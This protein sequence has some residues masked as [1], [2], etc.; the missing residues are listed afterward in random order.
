MLTLFTGL[1]KKTAVLGQI[2]L[3]C[4]HV[5]LAIH[6]HSHIIHNKVICYTLLRGAVIAKHGFIIHDSH[7]DFAINFS[8]V[9]SKEHALFFVQTVLT[10][11]DQCVKFSGLEQ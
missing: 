2:T 3:N 1:K 11:K 5:E 8:A 9:S 4:S 10:S 6:W 7:N